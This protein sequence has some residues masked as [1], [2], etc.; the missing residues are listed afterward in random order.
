M[1][2]KVVLKRT[3]H[4]VYETKVTIFGD[5]NVRKMIIFWKNEVSITRFDEEKSVDLIP[6]SIEVLF[7]DV[8]VS[9]HKRTDR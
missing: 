3:C 4:K 7:L 1:D 8:L 5:M 2:V 6:I 9:F